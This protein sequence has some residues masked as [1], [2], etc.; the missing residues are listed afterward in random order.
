VNLEVKIKP[1]VKAVLHVLLPD[2]L[3]NCPMAMIGRDAPRTASQLHSR[4][5]KELPKIILR[6][7]KHYIACK[8]GFPFVC[9][10]QVLE[11]LPCT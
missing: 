5:G 3:P 6:A 8:T 4:K 9:T 1:G 10:V 7:S 11:L 2:R